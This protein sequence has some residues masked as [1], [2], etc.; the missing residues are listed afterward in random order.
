MIVLIAN[1]LPDAVRGKLK[2]WFIEPKPNV[3]VSGIKDALADRVIDLVMRYTPPASGFI[4]FRSL[5]R[6]PGYEIHVHGTP[7]KSITL[8]TGL[9]LVIEKTDPPP[10]DT[11]LEF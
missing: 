4:L 2:L 7:T 8:L 3:F 1:D 11:I 5:P 10:S 6:P 9:Q